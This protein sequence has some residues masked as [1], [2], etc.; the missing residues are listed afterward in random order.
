MYASVRVDKY[1]NNYSVCP[2][3]RTRFCPNMRV[4][5]VGFVVLWTR[6]VYIS[7]D[8]QQKIVSVYARI[9]IKR[10]FW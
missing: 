6:D 9:Y 1:P 3:Y 2:I 10:S 7:W 4:T 8:E 5:L